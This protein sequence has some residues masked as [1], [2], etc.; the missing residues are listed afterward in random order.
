MVATR[1]RKRLRATG[2]A[3]FSA[4]LNFLNSAAGAG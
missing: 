3:S 1:L 4:Y 2:I